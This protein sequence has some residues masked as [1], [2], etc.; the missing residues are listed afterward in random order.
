[1]TL[2]LLLITVAALGGV[3]V[4]ANGVLGFAPPSLVALVLS[5]LLMAA[6]V[7]SGA[8]GPDRCAVRIAR[9]SRTRRAWWC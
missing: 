7:S 3:R 2:P 4:A 9:S 8:L 5:I 6:L 1:V